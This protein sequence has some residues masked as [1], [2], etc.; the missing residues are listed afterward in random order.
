MTEMTMIVSHL[1]RNNE[2]VPTRSTIT[3][4][5]ATCFLVVNW[6]LKVG[7]M[8]YGLDGVRCGYGRG[9]GGNG[10]VMKATQAKNT[11]NKEG[12]IN[13]INVINQLIQ[14]NSYE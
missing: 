12:K 10:W 1:N 8:G 9:L 4:R 5:N 3:T 6:A 11:K 14:N 13:V 2:A 7:G